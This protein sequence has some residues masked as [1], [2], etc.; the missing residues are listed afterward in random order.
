[1]N[2]NPK[3]LV[4]FQSGGPSPV[5]NTSMFGVVREAKSH[6]KDISFVYGARYGVDGLINDDI[7]DLGA[8]DENQLALLS[9]TP[10]SALG[11]V[12]HKLPDL[13]DPLYKQIIATI[14]KHNIGYVLVNG[15]NDSMDTCYKLDS[16]FKANKLGV[17]VLGIL[18]TIDND[19]VMTDHSLGYPSA[20][21]HVINFTKMACID[22][23]S[24]AHGKV[25]IIEVMGRNAGWLTASVDLLEDEN[26]PDLIYL[27]EVPFDPKNFLA[28]VKEIYERKGSVTVVA[29]EGIDIAHVNAGG[30]DEFGHKALEGVATSLS[31]LVHDELGIGTRVMELSLPQRGNPILSSPI[32]IQEAMGASRYAVK[33]AI[34][35]E[36]GKMVLIKRISDFPYKSDYFLGPVADIANKEKK[37]P[38]E[39]IKDDT[40]LTNDFRNYL[41]PLINGHREVLYNNGIFVSAHL[42]L[43]KVE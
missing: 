24:Y 36:S 5:I 22:N 6:P 8:E 15:G 3:A 16:T 7:V 35:G 11:S 18:K 2:S 28:R 23:V 43:K 30:I 38:L 1:M 33:Q 31:D 10:G 27:P 20:A 9:Q 25:L 41:R 17:K 39:W 40:S 19:L 37:I 12:R 14:K 21:R 32:D 26:R 34:K 42:A 13:S 4:Y 29:S